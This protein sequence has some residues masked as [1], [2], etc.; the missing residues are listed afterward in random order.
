[1][2]STG[3]L[4]LALMPAFLAA[5][6]PTAPPAGQQPPGQPPA[7]QQPGQP[8]AGQTEPAEQTAKPPEGPPKVP[9]ESPAGMLLVQ[10]KPDKTAVFEEMVGKLKSGLATTDDPK[11]RQQAQ[12]LTVYKTAEGLS[13]NAL[14][15]VKAEPA[16]PNSEYELFAM[17]QKTMTEEELRA[18]ETAE[19]WKRYA[20]AFAAGMGKLSLTPIGVT[21]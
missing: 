18:E 14:Y 6:T 4:A 20:D 19:M 3:V 9:F 1:V 7:G 10:I 16:V 2:I 5:Q 15:I 13:G 8:P 12:G 21:R 17:L 11:L